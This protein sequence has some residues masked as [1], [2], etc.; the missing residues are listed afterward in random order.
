M[1]TLLEERVR[2]VLHARAGQVDEGVIQRVTAAG[3]RPR[4]RSRRVE[5]AVGGVAAAAVAGTVMAVGPGTSKAYAGWTSTPTTPA[6]GQ[7]SAANRMCVRAMA[8]ATT[9]GAGA[10]TTKTASAW[11]PVLDDTRGPY[12]LVVLAT[13]GSTRLGYGACLADQ[14]AGHRVPFMDAIQYTAPARRPVPAPGMLA[15][16]LLA[17]SGSA[18]VVSGRVGA[19]VTKVVLVLSDQDE[20]AA[21]VGDGV[22]A[23]WWPSQAQPVSVKV[24]T[25]AG[26]VTRPFAAAGK[27]TGPNGGGVQLGW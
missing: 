26:T 20:V 19:G 8:R 11:Q 6:P 22:Y 1:S 5:A 27:S 25:P 9:V 24:T 2:S 3:Y 18:K 14:Q 12:T 4:V 10:R 17:G 13:G 23:A 16:T 7:S 15:S 21:T